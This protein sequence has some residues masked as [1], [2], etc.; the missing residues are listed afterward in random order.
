M[1]T[2]LDRISSHLKRGSCYEEDISNTQSG[3][4]KENILRVFGCNTLSR[5]SS[6]TIDLEFLDPGGLID[7]VPNSESI[8]ISPLRAGCH[9]RSSSFKHTSFR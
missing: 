3:G 4:S 2:L 1:N 6:G 7:A 9:G 8:L 5:G